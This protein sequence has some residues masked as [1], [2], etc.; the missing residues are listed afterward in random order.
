MVPAIFKLIAIESIHCF[1]II[2]TIDLTTVFPI[3]YRSALANGKK[4]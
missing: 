4:V 3:H 2:L 1:R